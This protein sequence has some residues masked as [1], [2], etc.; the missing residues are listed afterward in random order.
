MSSGLVFDIRKY[1]IHDGPGIRTLGLPQR[2]P[3]ALSLVPQPGGAGRR[4]ARFSSG[5]AL[6]R[7]AGR[8]PVAAAAL[9]A[10]PLGL[11]PRKEAGGPACAACPCLRRLRRGLP[12]RGPPARGAPDE[13]RGGDG[14]GDARTCPSTRS[15]AEA[16]PSREASPW[17]RASSSSTSCGPAGPRAYAAPSTPRDGRARELV[18][19]AGGLADLVLFDLK[20]VDEERH[21]AATGVPSGPILD[22]LRALAVVGRQDRPPRAADPRNQ[23]RVGRSRGRGER[24]GLARGSRRACTFCPYHDAGRGKYA[25]RG[26]GLSHGRRTSPPS[27]EAVREAACV[28]EKAGLDAVDRRL[29]MSERVKRAPRGELFREAELLGRAGRADDGVLRG[30]AGPRLDARSCAR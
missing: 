20:L 5:R 25:L 27:G 2:L 15:P 3:P 1:S 30:V 24:R 4:A 13:R 11:D 16:P 12:G 29:S 28:F 26:S 21:R 23:R 10:C 18:L 9:R 6:R 14:R 19:E 8:G 17:P 7:R 22:N